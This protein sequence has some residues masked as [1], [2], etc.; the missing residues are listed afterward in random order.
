MLPSKSMYIKNEIV[1]AA[2]IFRQ[3]VSV[4]FVEYVAARL[5]TAGRLPAGYIVE[6][7]DPALL[8]VGKQA[9]CKD[10]EDQVEARHISRPNPNR[11][12]PR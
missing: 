3:P 9:Q 5:I 12:H 4:S 2:S 7:S 1:G 10:T 11:R 8:C 6:Q